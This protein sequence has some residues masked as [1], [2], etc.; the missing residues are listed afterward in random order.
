MTNEFE[1]PKLDGIFLIPDFFTRQSRVMA[2]KKLHKTMKFLEL[3]LNFILDPLNLTINTAL[4]LSTL[5]VSTN[6]NFTVRHQLA[7]SRITLN[8]NPPA[9]RILMTFFQT[10]LSTVKKVG[11]D[12]CS[13]AALC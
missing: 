6:L 5:T 13:L 2:R 1:V 12:N 7:Y 10:F 4:S 11:F 3:V 9:H 8:I